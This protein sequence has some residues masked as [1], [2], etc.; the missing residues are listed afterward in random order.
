[1][2]V[3][4][5]FPVSSPIFSSLLFIYYFLLVTLMLCMHCKFVLFSKTVPLT[6]VRSTV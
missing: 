4:V 3:R 2:H 1:M 6:A 5:F